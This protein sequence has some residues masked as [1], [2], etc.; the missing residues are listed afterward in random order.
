MKNKITDKKFLHNAQNMANVICNSLLIPPIK[1]IFEKEFL[2]TNLRA[3]YN[4]SNFT[5]TISR[6]INSK[7][8]VHEINH[9]Q[10]DLIG[11]VENWEEKLV[12]RC[13]EGSIFDILEIDTFKKKIINFDKVVAFSK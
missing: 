2:E 9:Y 4:P 10:L 13:T 12:E 6:L 1:I 3:F 5:I 8:L 11:R 7:T